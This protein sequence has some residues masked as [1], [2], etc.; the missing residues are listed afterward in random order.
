MQW[1]DSAV[2]IVWT[3]VEVE[4]EFGRELFYS[5]V[6]P[7]LYGCVQTIVIPTSAKSKE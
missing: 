1:P 3:G 4:E 2:Q 7:F 5:A 6:L